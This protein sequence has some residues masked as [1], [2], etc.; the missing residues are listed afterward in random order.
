LLREILKSE[1]GFQGFV[2]SDFIFGLHD[3]KAS[4]LAGVDLEMPF[5]RQYGKGL[6][7]LVEAGQA[8]EELID[9]AVLRLLRQKIRFAQV[10]DPALYSPTAV[11]SEEHRA[12]ARQ[13]AVE[14]IVLLKNEPPA[15]QRSFPEMKRD[16]GSIF[17][18]SRA[19]PM[20]YNLSVSDAQ[21]FGAFSGENFSDPLLPL[22]PDQISRLAV[23]G[24]LA[25]EVNLGDRGSSMTHPLSAVPPLEGILAAAEGRFEVDFHEGLSSIEAADLARK[26]DAALVFVGL[27]DKDEGENMFTRG[28]DR[29]SLRLYE[30]DVALI[31]TVAAA[32]PRTAVILMGSGAVIIDNWQEYIPA[33]LLVWYPG[34]E[35]GH[36]IADILF[37]KANPSGKLPVVFPKSE[38]QLPPFDNH[39][40]AVDY[41]YFH[42][43]RWFDRKGHSPAF[44][45]GFGMSYTSYHYDDLLIAENELPQDGVL[46]AS[47]QVTN[48]G[49]RAGDEV[50][51]CYIGYPGAFV[52]RPQ[53]ELKG[54]K[55]I[56]LD[57]GET[58]GVAFEIPI[59]DL[60]YYDDAL[61]AWIV[62]PGIY[63]LYAG[64]SSA[65]EDLLQG[66]FKVRG[67]ENEDVHLAR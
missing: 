10:G 17:S 28:G 55:R 27:T 58:Q 49:A 61:A 63:R 31:L 44:P 60:A 22:L 56:H 67:N 42:G 33:I 12:L 13:V 53:K 18:F 47:V 11:A 66:K 32:N 2:M 8:P 3:G 40:P 64:A 39:S 43:Y 15:G 24:R 5:A 37:G 57:P 4:L 34:M 59:H 41:G 14:S 62:E 26:S 20:Q 51:Q 1:W 29:R 38:D 23:I 45:F 35:G 21:R 19:R 6:K 46:R 65:T 30:S 48:S 16:L 50:V 54:F 9:E 7:A 36:A 25:G 52:E